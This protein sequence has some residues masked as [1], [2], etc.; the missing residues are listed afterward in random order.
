M[1][2]RNSKSTSGRRSSRSSSA[3]DLTTSQGLYSVAQGAGGAVAKKAGEIAGTQKSLLSRIGGGLKRGLGKVLDVA[4]RFNY[5]GASATK[6]ILDD[7]TST[8]FL[9]GLKSGIT[10]ETKHTYSDVFTEAG[11]QPTS[12]MGKLGKGLTGFAFDVLLDPTTYV[13]FGASAGVKVGVKVAGVA[14][15]KTLSKE[16]AKLLAK[17]VAQK[18]GQEFGEEFVKEAIGNL[19]S[20]SPEL[21]KKFIDQGG[22]KFFGQTLV[23]G[24]R[25][26][27]VAKTIPGMSKLDKATEPLRNNLYALFNRDASAKFGKLPNEFV[28]LQQKW[29]DLGYVRG[30]D[31]LNNVVNIA[32]ANK[33]T[34]QEAEIITNAIE[35]KLPLADF[36]LENARKLIENGLGRSLKLEQRAGIEVGEL[37]NYVPHILVDEAVNIPFKPSGVRVSLGAINERTIEGTISEINER[38]GKEFFDT[39]II[40]TAA[41]RGVAS[42]RALTSKEF[43][44]E[45]AQKFGTRTPPT[46]YVK[47]GAKELEGLY[48]HPA[49]AEQIDKFGKAFTSDEATNAMLRAFDEAQNLWKASV[50]SIFP[51]F[52]GRNAI[53]NV[54]LNFLDIG[55]SAI[56]PAKHLLSTTLLKNNAD[57]TKLEKLILQGG[58]VGKNAGVQLD[59][60]LNK[61]VLTDNFGKEWTFG[62]IR[63]EIRDRRV[64]FGDEFTG[65]LD[66]RDSI[67]DKLNLATGTSKVKKNL[68]KVNPLSQQNVA[69]KA[70]R[71][72]GNAIEQ[73]ARVLNFM[74]N[75]ER[76]GD[77]VTAA[78]RT[79][80]FLFDYTNLSDFEKNVMRRLIPF[81]TFTRKNLELQ[82]TQLAKQPGK[83]ATQAK[84][85][86]NISKTM[87]GSSLT[88]EETKALPE[89]LQQGLGIVYSRDGDKIQIINELGTPIE[90]LFGSI[91]PNAILGSLS[92]VINVPLQ[93]A[94]G[95]HFFFDKDLKDVNNATAY[96]NAPQFI[97]DYIG[98]TVRKNKD[99][100]DRYIALNPTRLFILNNI[101]PSSRVVSTIGQLEAENVSGKLKILRLL[102]GLKPYGEDLELQEQI[103]EKAKIRELQDLL[104]DSGV[105]PIFRRSFIPKN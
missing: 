25:I 93:A 62:A 54:F 101:P 37:P 40:N 67:K 28:Q 1:G 59:L 26:S 36:R 44:T 12:K 29:R 49:I 85:F 14:T 61:K 13:T 27:G 82:V 104:E 60:L 38:F 18:S 22:I 69:F 4:Q 95:K 74:T 42:A 51:A 64:A 39:N 86:T 96:K 92:P 71:A 87:S 103:K 50:T 5:A 81:Y 80:Q 20:K 75:L 91:K 3:V 58:D 48:F 6:N 100:T 46:G 53:S 11:W 72:V 15:T 17:G 52:H 79:K 45:V 16:G 8:T 7:D 66:I 10:G 9:G 105:A 41:I 56:S 84:I 23:S 77:V 63:K 94:I 24:G 68:Q 73:Q 55:A 2:R 88:E 31:A 89:F 70:G 57:A 102:T 47:A 83:L 90:A 76:T 99:G 19:A 30:Q 43:L 32:K 78:E 35:H 98:F 65:F 21:Y 34:A 97:K 33:L